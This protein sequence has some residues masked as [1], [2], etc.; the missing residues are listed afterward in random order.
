MTNKKLTEKQVKRK[1]RRIANERGHEYVY[2]APYFEDEYGELV[3]GQE[4]YYTNPEGTPSCIVGVL[5][6]DVA[7]QELKKI[8][9][10]EWDSGTKYPN[11]AAISDVADGVWVE[12]VDL[13]DIFE[14]EAINLMERVQRRQ[15]VGMSWGE[16]VDKEN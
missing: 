4:C 16:A 3:Q 13:T 6:A 11:C 10:W 12:G 15:D 5:L 2:E 9:Q 14:D 7:P 8:Y 1:L